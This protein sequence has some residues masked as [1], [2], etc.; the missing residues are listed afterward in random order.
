MLGCPR[1]TK[2]GCHNPGILVARG[3]A[4]HATPNL[5]SGCTYEEPQDRSVH[6]GFGEH[7]DG[8]WHRT[9][10]LLDIDLTLERLCFR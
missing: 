2:A 9:P 4:L 8:A 5:S 1:A 7:D 10:T 3:T 6:L